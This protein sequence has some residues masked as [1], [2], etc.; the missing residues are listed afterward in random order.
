MTGMQDK[1]IGCALV[2]YGTTFNWGWIHA[3]WIQAAAGLRL[4]AVCTRTAASA[5]RAGRDHPG[6]DTG[7]DLAAMLRRDDVE[8]VCV[9][10][11]HNTH[12]AIAIQA[13]EA[14]KH[15]LV[16]KAMAV[17]VAECDAMIAAAR[18]NRR[19]LAVFHNRRHDGNIRAITETIRSGEL[20]DIYHLEF[21][22]GGYRAPGGGWYDDQEASGGA[23]HTY[24]PHV[25]DWMLQWVPSRPAQVMGYAHKLVWCGTSNADHAQAVIRFANGAV[26]EITVSSIAH[27]GKPQWYILGT[28]GAIVDTAQG[29][30]AGY[31]KEVVGPSAGSFRLRT[32]AGEREVPYRESDWLTYYVDLANHLRHG[33][34]VPV[35]AE[36][37]RL[38]IAVLEAAERSARS[39][40]PQQLEAG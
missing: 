40:Q 29:A 19:T 1:R 17:S 23:L 36:E 15:V 26:G 30:L 20:G 34:P 5:A 14:G 6:V 18:R 9:L 27:L 33:T 35:S 7:T 38:T 25:V 13:L 28:A 8:L 24:G 37:G 10:T 21:F 4:A 2:G 22:A 39:G 12:A 32:A 31:T 11:P 16:D 3:R